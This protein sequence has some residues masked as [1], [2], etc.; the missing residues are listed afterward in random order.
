MSEITVFF[1]SWPK[2]NIKVKR[3]SFDTP[4]FLFLFYFW[5]NSSENCF[6]LKDFSLHKLNDFF[7]TWN[8]SFSNNI[9]LQK[10]ERR[11]SEFYLTKTIRTIWIC[12]I[13][14]HLLHNEEMKNAILN[15]KKTKH[16]LNCKKTISKLLIWKILFVFG[17]EKVEV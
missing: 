5:E 6:S 15:S 17:K 1:F 11:I 12:Q 10:T 14:K 16:D 8:V 13:L 7:L 3:K 2:K 4:G 9:S